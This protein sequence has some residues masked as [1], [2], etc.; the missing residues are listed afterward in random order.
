MGLTTRSL[1]GHVLARVVAETQHRV[2]VR[3][4]PG[5]CPKDEMWSEGGRVN[6]RVAR[7]G[8]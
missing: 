2:R 7:E 1:L 6:P 5:D 4:L 8:L 3:V